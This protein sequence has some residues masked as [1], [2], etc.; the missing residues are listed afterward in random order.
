[1]FFVPGTT[2]LGSIYASF[3]FFIYEF[4]RFCK[5]QILCHILDVVNSHNNVS[6]IYPSVPCLRHGPIQCYAT[7]EMQHHTRSQDLALLCLKR[8]FSSQCTF[9]YQPYFASSCHLLDSFW[10]PP[11]G[12]IFLIFVP[13]QNLSQNS[14]YYL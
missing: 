1:M 5:S 3:S 9:P 14:F 7:S 2:P 4:E 13:V 12:V 8:S 6:H 10:T 11:E